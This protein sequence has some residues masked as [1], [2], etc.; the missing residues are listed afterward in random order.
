MYLN[1]ICQPDIY[2][3][4]NV[5]GKN[6][7]F[8]YVFVD[9]KCHFLLLWHF[10]SQQLGLNIAIV[11][12]F[13]TTNSYTIVILRQGAYAEENFARPGSYSELHWSASP[14]TGGGEGDFD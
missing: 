8:T 3:Q 1:D 7:H 2:S 11:F 9:C 4:L 5:V 10:I 13:P 6:S 12:C 14:Q